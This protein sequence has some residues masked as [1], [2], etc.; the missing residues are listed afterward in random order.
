MSKKTFFI[1]FFFL[2]SIKSY[3]LPD[4]KGNDIKK[5]NLC[6]GTTKLPVED[7]DNGIEY[8]GEFRRG[9]AN[10]K[11]IAIWINDKEMNRKW[12]GT[13]KKG[14]RHGRG[15]GYLF[16]E[17]EEY[18]LEGTWK[19]GK[20]DIKKIFKQSFPD[21]YGRIKDVATYILDDGTF[22]GDAKITFKDGSV[23]EA[24]YK[25]GILSK[26]GQW[27][28]SSSKDEFDGKDRKF[29]FSGE[30]SPNLPLSFP[31]ADSDP[32]L[33]VGCQKKDRVDNCWVYMKFKSLNLNG[34]TIQSEYTSHD[35]RVKLE[36]GKIDT[37]TV[38]N[39]FGSNTVFFINKLK[40]MNYFMH[41][42][43]V[44]LQFDHYGDG[45]RFYRIDTRG[46]YEIMQD[47]YPNGYWLDGRL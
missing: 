7:W 42:Y 40:L 15:I 29:F 23:I 19:N 26:A 34:G 32:F 38:T 4:C 2:F 13:W 27:Y 9:L 28:F 18:K 35:V 25:D 46:L 5:W 30:I 44:L 43:E 24:V 16:F 8:T 3:S 36:S 20:K 10:G 47:H 6:I 17:G 37:F 11:G 41:N 39:N 1:L 45:K 14:K 33:G 21:S 31:Y 12:E 22:N